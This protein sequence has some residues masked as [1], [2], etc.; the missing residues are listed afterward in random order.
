MLTGDS[1]AANV[2]VDEKRLGRA[3]DVLH[4]AAFIGIT[5]EWNDSLCLFHAMYGGQLNAHSFQNVRSTEEMSSKYNRNEADQHVTPEDDPYDWQLF[6][7]GKA[8]FR[9]RQRI[10]GLPIYEPPAPH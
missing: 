2:P 7:V 3:I 4:K 9:E 5:D 10:Y 8:I 6:L 1:C